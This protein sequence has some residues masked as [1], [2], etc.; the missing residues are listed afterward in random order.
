MN[1]NY[2]VYNYIDN[3]MGLELP[4]RVWGAITTL[5]NL[6]RDLGVQESEE[7]SVVPTTIIKFLGVLFDLLRQVIILPENKQK[8]IQQEL[9]KWEKTI[10]YKKQ[11]QQLAGKLQFA[12]LC[13]R[14]GRV[15]ICRLY[16]QIAEMEDGTC[17][18]LSRDIK[19]DLFWWSVFLQQYNGVSMM[20]LEELQGELSFATDASL[21][22]L[23]DFMISVI[24]R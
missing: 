20:W 17:T 23:G 4:D 21:T 5:G 8:D 15:F 11:L 19:Q 6:L 16:D 12:A 10:V 2:T 3:F 14:P 24:L 1:I 18:Q 13:V 7:K 22:G 9:K